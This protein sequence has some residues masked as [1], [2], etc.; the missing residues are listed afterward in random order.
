MADSVVPVYRVAGAPDK[1]NRP[2]VSW[3]EGAASPAGF[4]PNGR[5]DVMG[6][7]QVPTADAR[8]RLPLSLEVSNLDR[9]KLVARFGVALPAPVLY[10]VDGTPD[11]GAA[12]WLLS[13]RKVTNESQR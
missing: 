1:Y 2:T 8:L 7:G 5:R 11:R 4:Q 9:V 13:L 6:L 12:F 10:E 3:V